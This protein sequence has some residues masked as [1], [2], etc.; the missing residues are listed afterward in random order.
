MKVRSY[1]IAMLVLVVI[2]FGGQA[3]AQTDEEHFQTFPFNF[4]TPGA[5]P[6]AMGGAFIGRATDASAAVTNPA[7]LTSLTRR[8]VYFEFKDL[9]QPVARMNQYD[10]VLTGFGSYTGP[11][12]AVP[13]FFNLAWPVG[14]RLTVAGGFSE[15]LKYK[16]DNIY[17]PTRRSTTYTNAV[18]PASYTTG[19][20]FQGMA[21][22]ASLGVRVT[23]RVSAGVSASLQHLSGAFNAVRGCAAIT[24]SA[25]QAGPLNCAAA[26]SVPNTSMTDASNGVGLNAGVLLKAASTLSIG[27]T[28]AKAPQFALSEQ[29]GNSPKT[30]YFNVPDRFGAGFSWQPG[31]SRY[32]FVFDVDRVLYS[33]MAHDMQ[34]V[35]YSNW[36]T[37]QPLTTTGTEPAPTGASFYYK[38]ATEV[39]GGME[40]K[41]N[42]DKTSPNPLFLRFGMFTNPSHTMRSVNEATTA[43]FKGTNTNA[44][45]PNGFYPSSLPAQLL[46]PFVTGVVGVNCSTGGACPTTIALNA[47]D[48]GITLGTG[49]A[50]SQRASVDVAFVYTTSKRQDFVVSLMLRPWTTK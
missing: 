49:F 34:I 30:V 33:Q 10:S 23:D 42:R 4:A 26:A 16:A 3:F 28:A 25:N 41:L 5:R 1:L 29:V 21:Y 32:V 9:Y 19:L 37:F 38:D 12:V 17:L 7:G 8:Q 50:M 27:V 24:T 18:F 22:M 48:V 15:F 35:Y 13:S 43:G 31:L 14:S 39:H 36:S 44:Q 11:R 6:M 40:V 2:G 46:Q 47:T 45:D 20:N